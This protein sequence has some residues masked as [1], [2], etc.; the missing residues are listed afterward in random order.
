MIDRQQKREELTTSIMDQVRRE[1]DAVLS[2][3][4]L[5]SDTREQIT[6]DLIANTE[7]VLDACT[8]DELTSA[9]AFEKYLCTCAQDA[10]AEINRNKYKTQKL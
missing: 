6:K 5:S 10:R 1:I 3:A 7:R 8:L 2:E 9:G 4:E